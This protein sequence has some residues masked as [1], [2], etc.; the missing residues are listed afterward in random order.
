MRKTFILLLFTLFLLNPQEGFLN[1][2]DPI[3]GEIDVNTASR[4][5]LE[6]ITRIGPVL[7]E[8]IIKERP[9]YSL[10][11]LKRV[12]GIGETTLKRIEEEG[13]AK[14]SSSEESFVEKEAPLVE[15]T[16]PVYEKGS[17]KKQNPF[18]IFLTSFLIAIF[19][20]FVIVILKKK[21]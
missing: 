16:L 8:R 14:I 9:F 12:K 15:K 7:A 10:N 6:E 17:S 11:E 13:L 3:P 20:S 21:I 19:Y 18:S 2:E 4:E 5:E 1:F